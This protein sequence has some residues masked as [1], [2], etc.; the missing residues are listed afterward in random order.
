M[1]ASSGEWAVQALR[2]AKR[3]AR[4]SLDRTLSEQ[5]QAEAASFAQCAATSDYVEGVR[6]FIAKRKPRFGD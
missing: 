3:L 1:G 6:A 5:L 2:N 4:Q